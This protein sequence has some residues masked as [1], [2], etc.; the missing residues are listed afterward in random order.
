MSGAAALG[1]VIIGFNPLVLEWLR[2]HIN[3]MSAMW[4][5]LCIEFYLRS[6]QAGR[7]RDMLLMGLFFALSVLTLGYYEIYLLVFFALHGLWRVLTTP[8][9]RGGAARRDVCGGPGRS[10]SGAAGLATLLLAP[11]ALGGVAQPVQRADHRRVG[12]GR[13]PRRGG[14]GGPAQFPRP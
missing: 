12:A 6:W 8:G 5:V 2:G 9:G 10:W 14:L 11:Y 7:R 1:G 4:W 13:R 3:L